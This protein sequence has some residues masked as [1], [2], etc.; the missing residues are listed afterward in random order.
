MEVALVFPM[1]V[2]YADLGTDTSL[3]AWAERGTI[4]SAFMVSKILFET[5]HREE[6]KKGYE[7]LLSQKISA[8]Y[9][10]LRWVS[11]ADLASIYAE[12]GK[13][14]DSIGLLKE[15]VE[16][17]ESQRKTIF[18]EGSKIGF[19]GD[20]QAVYHD[21][22]R[23][24][25]ADKQYEKAFEYVER[26][27]S[28]ALVDLL[29]SKKE[30]AYRGEHGREIQNLL[31]AG[32]STETLVALQEASLAGSKTRG[33]RIRVN[34]DLKNRAPELASLVTV[35]Y[36][37]ASE[38]LSQIP[39]EEAL[40]EYYCHG[41]DIYAFILSDGRLQAV[42]LQSDGLAEEV[43][44][45]HELVG[46]PGS[47]QFMA[48]SRKLYQRL[49]QPVESC[50]AKRSLI[51]VPHGILH[52]LPMNALHDGSFY[53]I[54]RYRLR[55]MPSASVMKYL[56]GKKTD[57]T[58]GVLIF[59]NPDLGDPRLDLAYAEQEAK[60]ISGIRPGSRILLRKDAG[61]SAL[62]SYGKNYRYLHFATHGRFD[63]LAPLKSALMLAPDSRSGGMLSVDKIYSLDLD[64]DLVT[65]SACETGLSLIA[66][67]DDM[68]GLTRGFLYAG[69]SSVVASLWKVDDRA[70][71]ELMKSFYTELLNS[72]K[73]EALRK[74][75]L[76]TKKKYPH[77]YYWASFQ[78]TGNAR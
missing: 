35:T 14:K 51:V 50:L 78:L 77:P 44:A 22:I 34:E 74:A 6:A 20:K 27:K 3:D 1:F 52:Y 46:Q 19:V 18:S 64:A 48:V 62:R 45:F 12:E 54:D 39:A 21:L 15:A 53:L 76:E 30:F 24:L 59:G 68:V 71:A 10:R 65:L 17:I 66:N 29:A 73:V 31:A 5:Q 41:R 47:E 70:T 11:M 49:F 7:K 4:L 69:S 37:G 28:R 16:I 43:R 55:V 36:Q 57:K 67:G 75:Q 13:I 61:E 23:T 63:P 40:L 33:I 26:A 32:D 72:D 56:S 2:H 38:I 58:T 25:Y 42:E 9:E 8:D 60:A